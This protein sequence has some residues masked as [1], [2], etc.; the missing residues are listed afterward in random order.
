MV[1][2]ITNWS[3]GSVNQ[4][5]NGGTRLATTP[6]IIDFE[7]AGV[8]AAVD[9][10][11]PSRVIVT[12]SGGGGPGSGDVVGPAI[13]VDNALV[14]FD[15]TTG[16][17]I[18]NSLAVL[19]DLGALTGLTGLTTSGVLSSTGTLSVTS[20]ASIGGD[21]G[22]TGAFLSADGTAANPAISFAADTDTGFYRI[23]VDQI[24]ASTGGTLRT[25]LSTTLFT[26]TLPFAGPDGTAASPGFIF[27]SD[28]DNGLYLAAANTLGVAAAGAVAATFSATALTSAVPVLGPAGSAGAPAF[29]F[30]GDPDTGA[31]SA[32]ANTIGWSAGGTLR[33]SLSTTAVTS[34]LPVL[35]PDGSAAA[36]AFTFSSDADNGLY[37]SAAN[38]PAIAAAGALVA[39]FAATGVTLAQPL[40]SSAGAAATP[41]ISFSGDSNSGLYSAAADTLGWA[42]NGTARMTLSTTVLDLSV[43]LE[44]P[45]GAVGAPGLYFDSDSDTGIYQTAANQLAITCAATQSFVFGSTGV[46]APVPVRLSDGSASAPGLTWNSDTNTGIWRSAADTLRIATNAVDQ[47]FI[48]T[49]SFRVS[50]STIIGVSGVGTPPDFTLDVRGETCIVGSSNATGRFMGRGIYPTAS[51]PTAP[52]SA[53]QWD[54][55]TVNTAGVITLKARVNNGG[56]PQAVTLGTFA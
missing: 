7:G 19:S 43:L 12:V 20:D 42:T 13:A 50:Q 16:K 3:A 30:S 28:P 48:S 5:E 54:L 22:V 44:I 18:Q 47:V 24:G 55:Y 39:S 49:A 6:L 27:A 10:T 26:S 1:Q 36:P 21:L 11:N 23:G 9:P 41:S 53:G 45:V 56:T 52:A 15:G 17:L 34:T 25:T 2:T 32:A 40:L 14:R 8:S 35:A 38:T 31:Y 33:L 46:T 37:L 51:Q 4:I 29:S